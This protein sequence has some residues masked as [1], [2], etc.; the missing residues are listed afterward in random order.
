VGFIS[1]FKGTEWPNAPGIW[2]EAHVQGWKKVTD[3]VHAKGGKIYAQLWHLGRV[4]HPL[5]QCGLPALA[6]S[7]VAAKGGKFRYL[8]DTPGYATPKP[9]EN[10][11]DIIALFRQAAINAKKAGFDG[12]ELHSA[13]GYLPH[14]FLESHSN[15]R[16][17]EWGGSIE[18]RCRFV[19][20][21]IKTL[22]E[23]YDGNSKCVGIKLSP[24]GGYNDM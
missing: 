11:S 1:F 22:I 5:H 17:D 10:P 6:P 23:V 18:N 4:C 7:A 24:G 21:A 9:I 8:K 19:L 2:S 12:V 3:A 20:S 16:A 15:K 14:Q 13:N